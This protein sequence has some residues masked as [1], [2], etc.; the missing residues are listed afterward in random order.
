[1]VHP[2]RAG[3]RRSVECAFHAQSG[4]RNVI[5]SLAPSLGLLADAVFPVDDRRLAWGEAKREADVLGDCGERLSLAAFVPFRFPV[6]V[7]DAALLLADS[8]DSGA[9]AV[10][11]FVVAEP[12]CVDIGD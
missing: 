11:T 12:L 6:A 1:M 10:Q 5:G 7:P 4:K 3:H 2:G 9:G 8:G